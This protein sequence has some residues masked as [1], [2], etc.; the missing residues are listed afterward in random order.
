VVLQATPPGRVQPVGGMAL[1]VEGRRWL[2]AAM[3]MVPGYPL[4]SPRASR[5]SGP[6]SPTTRSPLSCT[7][8]HPEP[9]VPVGV[10]TWDRY[11]TTI[12]DAELLEHDLLHGAA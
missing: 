7:A 10:N 2:I 12:D 5:P 9:T 4:E 11:L 8:A 6:R 3:G 1:P